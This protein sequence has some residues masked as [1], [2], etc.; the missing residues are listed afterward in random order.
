[1]RDKDENYY[2]IYSHITYLQNYLNDIMQ[3]Q[4]THLILS[5]EDLELIVACLR[6][7]KEEIYG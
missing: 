6:I 3:D 7:I 1:M 2:K 4:G 5:N